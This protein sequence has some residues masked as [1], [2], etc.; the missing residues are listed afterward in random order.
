MDQ[1]TSVDKSILIRE[2]CEA[3]QDIVFFKNPDGEYLFA[4]RAFEHLYGYT[5]EQIQGKSDFDFL[6]KAE[7]EFFAA[8]DIEALNAGKQT[9]S[10][11]WQVNELTGDREC[12]QTIKSP[13]FSGGGRLMGLLGVVKNITRQKNAEEIL[14]AT[15]PRE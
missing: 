10:E 5:F 12:Y 1:L 6:T 15:V 4:N 11:A 3:V 13:V 9:V 2:L 14:R 7:A 8:R